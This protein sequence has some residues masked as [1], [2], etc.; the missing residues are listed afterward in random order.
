MAFHTS[1]RPWFSDIEQ[2]A[3]YPSND[4]DGFGKSPPSFYLKH[5]TGL[6]R[7]I[8]TWAEVSSTGSEAVI[9]PHSSYWNSAGS[10]NR[11][12]GPC[13]HTFELTRSS[14]GST[15]V[16]RSAGFSAPGQW[17]QLSV[18]VKLWISAT[19]FATKVFH[20][21]GWLLIHERAII[22]S[23]QQQYTQSCGSWR[24]SL[25]KTNKREQSKQPSI[26]RRGR[27]NFFRWAILAL[28]MTRDVTTEPSIISALKKKACP[29]TFGG[30]ISKP[31]K[32]KVLDSSTT[33][34]GIAPR[35]GPS[36]QNLKT[37]YPLQELDLVLLG[38]LAIP[39]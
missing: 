3:T 34:T 37:I 4:S 7:D 33:H 28:T 1:L 36:L 30:S 17:N 25:A 31:M 12:F 16:N 29:I 5:N 26:S 15:L 38:Q 13:S 11:Y 10:S 6:L 24:A 39:L 14:A 19:R 23:V 2:E 8:Q 20:Q 9:S 18:E 35:N 21:L 27:V 32:L 22:E